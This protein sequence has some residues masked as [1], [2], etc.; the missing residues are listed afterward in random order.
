[1]ADITVSVT[2]HSRPYEVVGIATSA[3]GLDAL[4]VILSALPADFQAPVLVVQ[5][6]WHAAICGHLEKLLGARCALPVRTAATG[7]AVEGRQVLVAPPG[8]HLEITAQRT[9]R[10]EG[11]EPVNHC[12]P[13]A[14]VLFTSLARHAG[15]RAIACVLTGSGSDG[16]AG[17]KAVR[18]AGGFVIVQS[19]R[20][21]A[22][23]DMPD[24]AIETGKADLVLPLRAIA[25]ALSR[26]TMFEEQAA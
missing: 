2:L 22:W 17:A 15:A 4:R 20:S 24:A 14:D 12:C 3:G 5:H 1:M 16:A 21:A 19:P 25:Y 23:R 10:V 8:R 6:R 26:L 13:A 11:K 18:A 9:C 7:M